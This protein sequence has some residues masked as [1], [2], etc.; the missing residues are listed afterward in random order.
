MFSRR[1]AY[2]AVWEVLREEFFSEFCQD[3]E[4][5]EI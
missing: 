2:R 4:L 1:E 3:Q 5:E